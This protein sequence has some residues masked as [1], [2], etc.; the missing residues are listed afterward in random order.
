MDL[1]QYSE[2]IP[3][4]NFGVMVVSTVLM[5]YFYM[6]SSS[7][8]QL[9]KKIGSI[10]Y[11]KSGQYR[12]IASIFEMIIIATYVIYY[13]YPLSLPIPQTFP[14]S[15]WI[16]FAVAVIIGVPSGYIMYRGVVDAGVEGTMPKKKG[17]LFC[18]HASKQATAN[19]TF[20]C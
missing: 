1:E 10:A 12:V 2:L 19:W 3:W 6:R 16:S 15:F 11:K 20:G 8:A 14:W 4:I 18:L 7:P 13:F 9:E 17:Q 5:F